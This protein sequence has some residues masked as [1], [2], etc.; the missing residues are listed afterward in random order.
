MSKHVQYNAYF[1]QSKLAKIYIVENVPY[2]NLYS[3]SFPQIQN[4]AT[5]TKI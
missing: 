3:L 4:E 1:I 5:T 2:T